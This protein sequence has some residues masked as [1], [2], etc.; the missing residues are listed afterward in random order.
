[1]LLL[2]LLRLKKKE[3]KI[4]AAIEETEKQNAQ[5]ITV[6]LSQKGNRFYELEDQ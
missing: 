3:R 1:M 2:L 5:V 4:V 6:S